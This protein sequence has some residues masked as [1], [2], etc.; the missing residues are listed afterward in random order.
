MLPALGTYAV[1]V[2][3]PPSLPDAYVKSIRTHDSDLPGGNLVLDGKT[4]DALEVMLHLTGG[5]IEGRA[6]NARQEIVPN[7]SIILVPDQPGP[8]RP[9]QLH[10]GNTDES[11]KFQFHALPPG[12]YDIY[13]WEDVEKNSWFGKGFLQ[14]FDSY[15][16]T[17]HVED[18]QKQQ[19]K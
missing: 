3:I 1:E 19:M 6:I 9:D 14:T 5:S 18:G 13:A 8:L 2:L 17:L 16:R 4:P 15:K 12:D 11:G 7:A 10:L